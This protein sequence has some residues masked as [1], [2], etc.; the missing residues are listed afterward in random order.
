[1]GPAVIESPSSPIQ[2]ASNKREPKRK[3]VTRDIRPT[4]SKRPR[5]SLPRGPQSIEPEPESESPSE[6]SSPEQT[7]SP[8]RT[9]SKTSKKRNQDAESDVETGT[10]EVRVHKLPPSAGGTRHLNEID[11]FLQ[12][13]TEVLA[14]TAQRVLRQDATQAKILDAFTEEVTVRLI[15]MTDAWDSH[16]VLLGAVRK[17]Q[18]RKNLLRQELLAIRR[19]RGE[20]RR[21]ME[22]VRQSHEL[23]QQE[24]EDL[25]RQSDFIAEMEDLKARVNDD[26]GEDHVKV[27]SIHALK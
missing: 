16:S 27:H 9:K 4:P 13:A 10:I 23:G 24:M 17:A 1:M 2:S 8:P 15:E 22:A 21:E 14:L 26:E 12:V 25:K 3:S 19:E 11:G 18:K 6:V 7:P 20:I 5:R